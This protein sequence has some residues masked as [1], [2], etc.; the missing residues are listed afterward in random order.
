MRISHQKEN[1]SPERCPSVAAFSDMDPVLD[2]I[3]RRCTGGIPWTAI[4][5]GAD[6][7]G[8]ARDSKW[9]LY[10]NMESFTF[11]DTFARNHVPPVTLPLPRNFSVV[12]LESGATDTMLG[13]ANSL[14]PAR[15][16]DVL[17]INKELIIQD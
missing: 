7:Q 8:A 5:I 9:A 1:L 11:N 12:F 3:L 13:V 15:A 16:G 2:P 6:T 10:F 17:I 4:P 14:K